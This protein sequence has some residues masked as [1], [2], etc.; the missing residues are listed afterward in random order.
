MNKIIYDL[1]TSGL[2]R[3]KSFGSYHHPSKTHFYD[4]ARIVQIGWIEIDDN[5]NVVSSHSY[6]IKPEG[7]HIGK[8]SIKVHGITNEIAE[9]DGVRF[10]DAMIA[11]F[12]RFTE[13][14]TLIGY[15]TKFDLN[16]LL[17]ELYRR[18]YHTY[19]QKL[20]NVHY[21]SDVM[22]LTCEFFAHT[23][24]K[25]PYRWKKLVEAFSILCKDSDETLL[26]DCH[27]ALGDCKLTL[28]IYKKIKEEFELFNIETSTYLRW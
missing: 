10:L 3:C 16:C 27:D 6:I 23:G 11:F 4:E 12:D 2:P 14:S 18:G 8:E 17:S 1:E 26:E 25:Q 13:I 21:T 7:Y 20:N 15:N 5:D 9:R 24:R 19:I 28:A 22:H